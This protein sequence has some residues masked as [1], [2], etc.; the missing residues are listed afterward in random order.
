MFHHAKCKA[1]FRWLGPAVL[2]TLAA[3]VPVA[4]SIPP[5]QAQTETAPGAPT[6]LT[7]AVSGSELL[8]ATW[9]APADNGGSALTGYS[10]QYRAGSDGD[11]VTTTLSTTN[12]NAT[13]F[14]LDGGQPY[15][16]QVAAINDV[17]TGDYSEIATA[18]A[19]TAPDP[20]GS[21]TATAEERDVSLA[22]SAPTSTYTG[23]PDLAGYTVRVKATAGSTWQTFD[24]AADAMT[25]AAASHLTLTA[26]ASYDFQVRSNSVF[27]SVDLE[28][29][30]T[31]T[32]AAT[33]YDVPD[34]PTNLTLVEG[35]RQI[36]AS[37]TAPAGN[38]AAI[39]GY[40]VQ[41]RLTTTSRWEDWS[42]AG[43]GAAATITGLT[44]GL[45]YFVQVAAIN[46][47]GAGPFSDT[48]SQTPAGTPLAP[49]YLALTAGEGQ[50]EAA[51]TAPE[52]NGAAVTGYSVQFRTATA[53]LWSDWG[54]SGTG[55]A[56]TI[57]G[58]T[59]GLTYQVRVAGQNYRGTGDYSSPVTS[60]ATGE[61]DKPVILTVTAGD[62]RLAIRWAAPV[63]TGGQPLT[64]YSLQYRRNGEAVW[65]AAVTSG[66]RTEATITGLA[67][68]AIYQVQ[69]AARNNS[70]GSDYSVAVAGAPSGPPDAPTDLRLI[71]GD[72]QFLATWKAPVRTGGRPITGYSLQYRRSGAAVWQDAATT[73]T[74]V[75]ATVTGLANS[76]TYQVRVAAQNDNGTGDYTAHQVV[77]TGLP[78]LTHLL[79][80]QIEETTATLTADI[81]NPNGVSY[82][83][84]ARRPVGNG[85]L[86]TST[87]SATGTATWDLTG[88]EPDTEYT[89]W[90]SRL[91]TFPDG[92]TAQVT[93]ST[94]AIN[95]VSIE[96]PTKYISERGAIARV[97]TSYADG[98]RREVYLRY[99][100]PP[101][102]G[103]WSQA[104]RS[105][106]V[107]TTSSFILS[108]LTPNS[109]YRVQASM[110]QAAFASDEYATFSTEG[111]S[112]T[113]TAT[114]TPDSYI[115][116]RTATV[117]ATFGGLP[118]GDTL[119]WLYRLDI[120]AADGTDADEC[121]GSGLGQSLDLGSV[122]SATESREGTVL[123]ACPPGHYRAVASIGESSDAQR[124]ASA[125]A[126]FTI[127]TGPTL[128]SLHV[129]D[130]D[131][132]R[133][134][135]TATIAKPRLTSTVHFRHRVASPT[136]PWSDAPSVTAGGATIERIIT[137]LNPA[138]DYELQSSL[139]P[140]FPAG[141]TE[142]ARFTTLTPDTYLADIL[143]RDIG[144]NRATAHVSIAYPDGRDRTIYLEVTGPP[145]TFQ[146]PVQNSRASGSDTIAEF[147]LTGLLPGST[148]SVSA[149]LSSRFSGDGAATVQFNT[150]SP[151]PTPTPWPALAES[152]SAPDQPRIQAG[153]SGYLGTVW[154]TVGVEGGNAGYR[155]N[156]Y[157]SLLDGVLPGPMFDDGRPRSLE[158]F[159]L[160]GDSAGDYLAVQGHTG[161]GDSPYLTGSD[162]RWLR[163][164]VR[165]PDQSNV[166]LLNVNLWKSRDPCA[167]GQVCFTLEGEPETAL[168]DLD[169][170]P[171]A[172]DFFDA[173]AEVITGNLVGGRGNLVF[174]A[175]HQAAEGSTR[176]LISCGHDADCYLSGNYPEAMLENPG[177]RADF[178]GG[179]T[180]SDSRL[181]LRATPDAP[182]RFQGWRRVAVKLLD[183]DGEVLTNIRISDLLTSQ[184]ELELVMDIDSEHAPLQ[185][186][187]AYD[188]Q[189]MALKFE[190]LGWIHLLERTPGGPVAG[191][192]LLG[193]FAGGLTGV[194]FRRTA[195]PTRETI[196][197]GAAA[198]GTLVLPVF[199]L[200]NLF[201]TGG[202][203]VL[204]GIASVATVFLRSRT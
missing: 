166:I 185:D 174:M 36:A 31:S 46:R 26:G 70:G 173:E 113:A 178:R 129:R 57:T 38:G 6:G 130:T 168:A 65:Q 147:P 35:D 184:D 60:T 119:T 165:D 199:G 138:N 203:L 162:L 59:R 39:S 82:T 123:A 122:A 155:A 14:N 42:H 192:L 101:Q 145:V 134:T 47:A 177:G 10:L 55:T 170:Q 181:T 116:G 115:K 34:A 69:V 202:L 109:S 191:Q 71:H 75:R 159:V 190:D 80:T 189:I 5:A 2:L 188:G 100:D 16:F 8:A 121:E 43:S 105:W 167:A 86:L 112:L 151:P 103:T 1:I 24:V 139:S 104:I 142:S 160:V 97:N 30:Y 95:V 196:I 32:V 66:I 164:Q 176:G 72:G 186:L 37:W 197:L 90:A 98:I 161:N 27:G 179:I 91:K 15:D 17:G 63:N 150:G 81:S 84:Y 68:G 148:Y 108:G 4:A 110:D 92:Q 163:L 61:P 153:P 45:A 204:A 87:Q 156:R 169:G 23:Q 141:E 195:S 193:L 157:G 182:F 201:W 133:T 18:T 127:E 28:G 99:E 172:V 143:I 152:P 89:I 79:A 50:I 140:A 49:P 9:T 11:W 132:N 12:T 149:S 54:H 53:T 144:Q 77:T 67:N 107:T 19:Q 52:G 175:N 83:Y 180:I 96:I 7:V 135:A 58:L 74:Q 62:Q 88:L 200:G 20:P 198:F 171:V 118:V 194:R 33:P 137:G 120:L 106:T 117:Q 187:A 3:L 22:W 44:N 93:F 146:R 136:G 21:L 131:E 126:E 51:W 73:G 48:V 102:S 111:Y 76:Q 85:Y 158:R 29:H 183:R 40:S 124:I 41:Y 94:R 56:A 128:A 13:V 125:Q 154:L 78:I 25:W 64:G 114:V